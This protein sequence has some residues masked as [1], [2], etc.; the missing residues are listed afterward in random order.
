MVMLSRRQP[1]SRSD[2]PIATA[3]PA[4]GV[5]EARAAREVV[6][7]HE[8]RNRA[9]TGAVLTPRN[10]EGIVNG[11]VEEPQRRPEVEVLHYA[12]VTHGCVGPSGFFFEPQN[13]HTHE[14]NQQEE[15]Q[16]RADEH[17]EVTLPLMCIIC[18]RERF[19]R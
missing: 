13:A 14:G 8:D 18:L 10:Q 7:E 2:H 5:Q 9:K 3:P 1:A 17:L 11:K 12:A 4:D 6:D 16:D 19:E 15:V